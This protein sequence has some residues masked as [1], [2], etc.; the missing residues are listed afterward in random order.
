MEIKTRK[1]LGKLLEHFNLVG[2]AAEIG[3]AEGR[4]SEILISQPAIEKLYMIDAW[5]QL[6]QKGD[7][8]NPQSWHDR[9]YQEALVRTEEFKEKRI[10]LKGL[11]KDMIPLIPDNSLV[12][13]YID[14]SHNYIDCLV[15]LRTIWSKMKV[16]SIISGHDILNT[17]YGV[18]QAV[19][20]FCNE[21][22]LK[23]NIIEEDESVNASFWLYKK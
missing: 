8:H 4:H 16:G 3:V 17:A 5:K 11:S 2:H 21:H 6:N 22:E 9:N 19:E 10:V 12:L 14:A 15:D 1:D 7:G 13:S 23:I 18:N 20:E